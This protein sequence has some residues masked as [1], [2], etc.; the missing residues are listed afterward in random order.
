MM[1]PLPDCSSAA[2]VLRVSHCL[3]TRQA[4]SAI[5][6]MAREISIVP[7]PVAHAPY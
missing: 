5:V 1:A 7:A 2:A 4:G 6:K 3:K